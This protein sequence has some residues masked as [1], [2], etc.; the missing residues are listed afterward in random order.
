MQRLNRQH[1]LHVRRL[2][3]YAAFRSLIA[4][5][6]LLPVTVQR[7]IAWGFATLLTR[8]L[9][10]NMTRYDVATQNIRDSF[11]D[12]YSDEEI[13]GIIFRMWESLIRLVCEVVQF[14]RHVRCENVFDL[15]EF[16]NKE[17]VIQAMCSGRPV[18][19][20]SGHFGNWEVAVATFGLFGFD[21]GVVARTLDN[22][23]LDDWFRRFRESTGHRMIDKN[24]GGGE[25]QDRLQNGRHIA[26]LADQDAG[27][28]GCFVDFFGRPA[29]TF[30]SIA[31]LALRYDALI[32]V[33]YAVRLPDES[34]S[35]RWVKYELGCEAVID[36]R[37]L[38]GDN[39]VQEL[40]Q[41]YT[42]ALESA[43]RRTPDQYFWVHRRWKSKPKTKQQS[44]RSLKRDEPLRKAG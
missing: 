43:I 35:G 31:L 41:Q 30:K 27:R 4:F 9:P 11:G 44:D 38:P 1:W 24:G 25:M 8:V 29:S 18:I 16:R 23:W 26:L 14:S 12:Q 36:P 17:Q 28:R 10:K 40:T 19:L 13:D 5:I 3:E 21:M 15:I 7:V 37:E 34:H 33:G 22:P 42:T 32:C 2:L 20:L 6:W 39:P